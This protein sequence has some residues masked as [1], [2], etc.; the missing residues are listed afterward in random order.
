[1]ERGW[2][3][4]LTPGISYRKLNAPEEMTDFVE[5]EGEREVIMSC[6]G[7]QEERGGMGVERYARGGRSSVNDG[8]GKSRRVLD[9]REG[10]EG[11]RKSWLKPVL[12][13]GGGG[14]EGA[15]RDKRGRGGTRTEEIRKISH[16]S[17][18]WGRR[19]NRKGE[20]WGKKLR[21][22]V[23]WEE[24]KGGGFFDL[25]GANNK[26]GVSSKPNG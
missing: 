17:A 18:N 6:R 3:R 24:T 15:R 23:R 1:L 19:R 21:K 2:R 9:E 7:R 8:R 10:G 4:K 26:V 13:L 16:E 20:E 11:L 5:K 14:F 22:R 12:S 25:G